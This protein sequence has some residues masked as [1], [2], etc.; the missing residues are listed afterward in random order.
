[1][2]GAGPAWAVTLRPQACAVSITAA[3]SSSVSW[4]VSIASCSPAM[5]P[6]IITLIRSAPSRICDRAPRRKPSAPSHST[7]SVPS[8][9]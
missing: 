4:G 5:P 7:V 6:E 3:I 2:I 9:P 8:W 1:M